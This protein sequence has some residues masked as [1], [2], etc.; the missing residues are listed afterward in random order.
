MYMK[1]PFLLKA[2]SAKQT[3]KFAAIR[4]KYNVSIWLKDSERKEHYLGGG[5]KQFLKGVP[6]LTSGRE[7]FR[8]SHI[9][10]NHSSVP[11]PFKVYNA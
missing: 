9:T 6:D 7:I 1:E 8:L 3:S 2:M 4:R 10:S 5:F 11:N